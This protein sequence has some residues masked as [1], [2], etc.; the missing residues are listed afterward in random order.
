MWGLS[1]WRR[2]T[3][4]VKVRSLNLVS[5]SPISSVNFHEPF[6][7]LGLIFFTCSIR[8]ILLTILYHFNMLGSLN[9]NKM[10]EILGIIF[11]LVAL[12][13]KFYWSIVDLQ[14]CVNFFYTKSDSV[15]HIYIYF[16][17]LFHYSL[18]QN[19]EYSSQCFYW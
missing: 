8:V 6:T 4:K 19:I 9:S 7:C 14:H 16:H 3:I 17:I 10:F 13:W 5:I 11:T 12:F 1:Q 2:K 18:S 15:I